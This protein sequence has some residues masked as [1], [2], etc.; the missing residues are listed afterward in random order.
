SLFFFSFD[1]F[2]SSS[3]FS[4][5]FSFFSFFRLTVTAD[6][7]TGF[8]SVFREREVFSLVIIFFDVG[9]FKFRLLL[10]S[11]LTSGRS[12]WSLTMTLDSP[13]PFEGAMI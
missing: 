3:L 11:D 10:V 2:S 9:L 8:L 5:P 12:L 1:S 6:S 13:F 4:P 7:F